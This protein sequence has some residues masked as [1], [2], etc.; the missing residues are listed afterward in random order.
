MILILIAIFFHACASILLKYGAINMEV[1]NITNILRNYFYIVSLLFLLFQAL[2]WQ[3]AL[4]K[5]E[6]H[7]AYTF[8]SLYYPM[9]MIA[10]YFLFGE[11][12]TPGNVTGIVLIIA[13]LSLREHGK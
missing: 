13:G 11:K 3:F 6:L 10:S 9:I 8:M 1:Y 12:I 7:H 2:S 4:K 5:Y